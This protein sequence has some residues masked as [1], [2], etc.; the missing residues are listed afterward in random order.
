MALSEEGGKVLGFVTVEGFHWEIDL[1]AFV[2]MHSSN[3]VNLL[4]LIVIVETVGIQVSSVIAID[5]YLFSAWLESE[6][7]EWLV[8]SRYWF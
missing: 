4:I 8:E 7:D 6:C 2:K 1:G 5:E 3:G